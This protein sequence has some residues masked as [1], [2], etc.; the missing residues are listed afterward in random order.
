MTMAN[1]RLGLGWNQVPV[2]QRRTPHKRGVRH[3]VNEEASD[4]VT[5]RSRGRIP[6]SRR[7]SE[8]CKS[9]P[10]TA[11]DSFSSGAR[12]RHWKGLRVG[13]R[14]RN[15]GA[16]G[17][18]QR[19]EMQFGSGE[20]AV[21]SASSKVANMPTIEITGPSSLLLPAQ[22]RHILVLSVELDDSARLRIG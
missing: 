18:E 3:G 22:L 1:S 12:Y 4:A 6:C 9:C 13:L 20:I 10:R 7:R 2:E 16:A 15:G 8:A 17:A 11:F 14:L 19:T 5:L 21:V